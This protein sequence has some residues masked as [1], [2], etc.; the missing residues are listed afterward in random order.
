ME[1]WHRIFRVLCCSDYR[2]LRLETFKLLWEQAPYYTYH[3]THHYA[4]PNILLI[5][6]ANPMVQTQ[7]CDLRTCRGALSSFNMYTNEEAST[8]TKIRGLPCLY[9]IA[10]VHLLQD[11]SLSIAIPISLSLYK[12]IMS[13]HLHHLWNPSTIERFDIFP[14]GR[15]IAQCKWGMAQK[16]IYYLIK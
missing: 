3:L 1:K 11:W 4:F 6:C 9:N 16:I 2:F 15:V 7:R 12:V 5:Q 10:L 8:C 14:K 13:S